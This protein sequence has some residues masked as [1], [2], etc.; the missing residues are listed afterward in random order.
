[1]H[2]LTAPAITQLVNLTPED[3]RTRAK[4]EMFN[5]TLKSKAQS[6]NV[7][8]HCTIH[9]Y[10]CTV[11]VSID[12][13]NE[14]DHEFTRFFHTRG[15]SLKYST[16]DNP[17]YRTFTTLEHNPLKNCNQNRI[18]LMTSKFHIRRV[19]FFVIYTFTCTVQVYCDMYMYMF[20]LIGKYTLRPT[21]CIQKL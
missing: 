7:I 2:K 8:L 6:A 5:I 19:F 9:R 18:L 12:F 1:M 15:A 10:A 13:K 20:C 21:Y 4:K 17:Q 11:Y 3:K 16:I 14:I